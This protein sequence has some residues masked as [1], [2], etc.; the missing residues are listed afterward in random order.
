LIVEDMTSADAA[1]AAA[2]E[3]LSTPMPWPESI[4]HAELAKSSAR[5]RVVRDAGRLVG[6]LVAWHIPGEVQVAELAVHPAFRRRGAARLL[7]TDALDEAVRRDAALATLEVRAGNAAARA[8]YG[9]LGFV[10]TGRRRGYYEGRE[11][12]VLMEKPLVTS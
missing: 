7:M 8:L 3:A 5:C 10:E 12:A 4:F 9:S 1:E 11:D 6:F 2:V